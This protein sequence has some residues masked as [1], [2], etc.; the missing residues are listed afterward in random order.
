MSV[1]HPTT[2][3]SE[4]QV[5]QPVTPT[6]A[7]DSKAVDAKPPGARI[8]RTELATQVYDDLRSFACWVVNGR[9]E[10]LDPTELLHETYLKLAKANRLDGQDRSHFFNL[11][12]KVMRQVLA[13]YA[14]SER[15]EKRGGGRLR[16]G[17]SQLEVESTGTE[18]RSAIDAADLHD[19]LE[20]LSSLDKRKAD[21][22][23]F[24]F[25]GGM[26][27]AET[28]KALGVSRRTVELDWRFARA[29]LRRRLYDALAR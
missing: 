17:L 4:I 23:T 8:P 20:L 22:V 6:F 10:C 21:V 24:R 12:A 14:T 13:D 5:S 2:R 7:S 26:S 9:G 18:S 1:L 27:I 15:A 16:V 11:A 19:A 3:K 28:A 29:W 25:L